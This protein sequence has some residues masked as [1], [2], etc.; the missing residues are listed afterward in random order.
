MQSQI[1]GMFLYL[2][3]FID[4][5]QPTGPAMKWEW[6]LSVSEFK[7]LH[8][9]AEWKVVKSFQI[10]IEKLFNVVVQKDSFN[11]LFR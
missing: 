11:Y 9:S 6:N 5:Q 4:H 3:E 7:K 10:T 2:T 1:A 8:Y